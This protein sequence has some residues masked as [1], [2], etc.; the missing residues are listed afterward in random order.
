VV[1]EWIQTLS[2][3]LAIQ[4][5]DL[6]LNCDETAWRLSPNNLRDQVPTGE[7]IFLICDV[8]MS[9][10][11]APLRALATALNI[12]LLSLSPG[13]TDQPLDRMIVGALKSIARRL[14]RRP[15]SHDPKLKRS[16]RDAVTDMIAARDILSDGTIQAAW[17]LYQDEEEWSRSENQ[18]T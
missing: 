5:H 10:R 4:D 17:A 8:H 12:T 15:T 1:N 7:R 11:T 6:I 9:H 13:A 16:K 18:E 2:N 3:L 14:S